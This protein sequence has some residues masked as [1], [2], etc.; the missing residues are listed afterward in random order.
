MSSLLRSLTIFNGLIDHPLQP[1]QR[2]GTCAFWQLP[3]MVWSRKQS[4][5]MESTEK[6][7]R[8]E[9]LREAFNTWP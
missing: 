6:D 7:L 1:W 3:F 4:G 5:Q 2:G 8:L 9:G